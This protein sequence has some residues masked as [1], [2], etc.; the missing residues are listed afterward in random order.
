[1][2]EKEQ[3]QKRAIRLGFLASDSELSA[4]L[5][6][7]VKNA[8][9]RR[10]QTIVFKRKLARSIKQARQFITHR[11]ILV[12]GQVIDAPGYIVPVE[13]EHNISFIQRSPFVSEM[14][15]ERVV[16]TADHKDKKHA[17][18]SGADEMMSAPVEIKVEEASDE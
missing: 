16:A 11:H 2:I 10:L 4:I 1:M 17:K 12:D 18:D 5:D 9:S 13:A 3:L 15:P 8:L 6:M 14:H 7:T